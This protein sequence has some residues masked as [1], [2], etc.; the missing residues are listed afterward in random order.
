MTDPNYEVVHYVKLGGTP[1]KGLL[2]PNHVPFLLYVTIPSGQ[3]VLAAAMYID[4]NGTAPMPGGCLT[5]W[6]EHNNLCYN[7][8]TNYIST[9]SPC[10]PGTKLINTGFMFHVWQVPVPGGA[11]ALGPSDLQTVEASIMAADN[12]SPYPTDEFNSAPPIAGGS[13]NSNRK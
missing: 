6:H 9:F 13:A 8:A 11:L 2:D 7:P 1:A 3:K 12:L 5:Q 10:P 4:Q